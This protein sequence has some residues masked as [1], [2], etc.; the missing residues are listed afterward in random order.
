MAR[1]CEGATAPYDVLALKPECT[2]VMGQGTGQLGSTSFGSCVGLVLWCEETKEGIVAHYSG[3]LGHAKFQDRAK[4][5]TQEILL[6]GGTSGK[7]WK[8][9][10]FGGV[11]LAKGT[12]LIASSLDQTK[13]LID[14]VR[15]GTP[16]T[17]GFAHQIDGYPGHGSVSLDLATGAVSFGTGSGKKIPDML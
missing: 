2:W 15:D 12:D 14:L 3:S 11:S 7:A 16:A 5:D 1:F 6:K 4:A 13:A 10:V 9:W 8:A 17:G